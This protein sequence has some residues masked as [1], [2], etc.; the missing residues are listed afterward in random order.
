M[1]DKNLFDLSQENIKVIAKEMDLSEKEIKRI[2][3]V[4]QP[5]TSLN[6]SFKK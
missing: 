3:E 5:H 1:R 6:K 4:S 2:L